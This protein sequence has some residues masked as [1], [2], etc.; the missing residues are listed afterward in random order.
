[1]LRLLTDSHVPPAVARAARKLAPIDVTPL[2]DWR[3]GRHLHESDARLLEL[4]WEDR[5][6]FLTYDVNTVPLVVKERLE[7]GLSHAGVVYVSARYRQNAVGTIARGLVRLW[8]LEKDL[9]W[10]NRIRFLD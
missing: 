9:D 3:G 4:A 6:T 2:R 7:A 8:R 1:M 10:I 5:L